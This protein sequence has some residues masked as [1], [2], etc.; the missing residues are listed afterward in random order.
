MLYDIHRLEPFYSPEPEPPPIP[1]VPE[2]A[3]FRN[4]T[5]GDSEYKIISYEANPTMPSIYEVEWAAP[6]GKEFKEWN[7][8]SDGTG[9]SYSVGDPATQSA[10]YYAIW[11]DLV[12]VDYL[13]TNAEL[14]SIADAIR[15]KGG[16]YAPLTYPEGFVDAIEDIVLGVDVSGTTA[17]PSV[18]ASGY[19]FRG[20]NGAWATGTAPKRSQSDLS[21]SGKT[22]TVPW[23]YYSGQYTKDVATGTEG[24]PTATKGTVSNNSIAVTPSVTNTAGYISGST[25][26]GTAVTVSAS[27]LVSG[28]KTIS[29]S[30]TTDVTNY[31]SVSVSAGSAT[32]PA[33][34]ITSAPSISVDSSGL[35]TATNSKTQNVTP[36][37]SAGYVSSG[38]AGT[39]TVDGSNT[40]Q[41]TVQ[42]AQTITPTTSNQTIASG[43]YLT[44]AQTILGDV[45]LIAEN[46]RQNK[47][48]F[49]ITGTYTFPDANGVS[50]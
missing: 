32:T 10:A 35:I 6:A 11:Q 30:G 19:K 2:Y 38:T 14:G 40:S 49:G 46:I 29:A 33:T 13:T 34:T 48:I 28:T 45:N 3:L 20:S 9:D 42:S 44:G 1:D 24:T 37:V 26:T 36:A 41:L 16:T 8:S 18:V 47:T 15:S 39:I 23:G 27:E 31:A 21:A 22:V 17:I 43:K 7:K 25:K 50:F 12:V 4:F 5:D